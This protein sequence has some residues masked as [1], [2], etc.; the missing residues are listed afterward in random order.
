MYR[1]QL[2]VFFIMLVAYA[3]CAFVTYAFFVDQLAAAAV[4]GVRSTA[5][6]AEERPPFAPRTVAA[7]AA[8]PTVFSI[9]R[10]EIASLTRNSY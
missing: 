5:A 8:A 3:L 2:S 7:P 6:A 10:R 1:K 9:A 4:V